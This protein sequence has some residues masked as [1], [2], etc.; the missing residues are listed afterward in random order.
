M[1][2]AVKMPG[3]PISQDNTAPQLS[4]RDAQIAELAYYNAEQ[5][6]FAPGHEVEDW[7]SAEQECLLNERNNP[8][9]TAGMYAP[10]MA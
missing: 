4:V 3:A 2:N 9:L 7:L 6:G 8:R 1:T 5:R 10:Y